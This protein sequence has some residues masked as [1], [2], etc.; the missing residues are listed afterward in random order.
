M[1]RIIGEITEAEQAAYLTRRDVDAEAI[2]SALRQRQH[3]LESRLISE[4]SARFSKGVICVHNGPGPNP[5]EIFTSSDPVQWMESLAGWLLVRSYTS[6]PVDTHGIPHP[7]CEDDAGR[8]YASIF[9]QAGADPELLGRLGP[10]LGLSSRDFGGSYDPSGCR[11]FPLIREKIGGEPAQFAQVHRSLAYDVGLTSQLASLFLLLFIHHERPEHQVQLKDDAELSMADGGPLLGARLTPDL[12]PLLAW[13]GQLAPKAVSI[14]PESAPRPID[15]RHHLSVICP[16]IASTG[17]GVADEGLTQSVE[18]ITQDISSASRI[19]DSL[20]TRWDSSPDATSNTGKLRAALERLGR[21]SGDCYADTYYSV[22]AA[23]PALLDL[24]HDLETL[25]QLVLLD[26]NSSEI[27][28]AQRYIAD[29]RVP[30]VGFPNLAVDRDA[31]LTGLSPSRLTR[32]RS[33]GWN[34][35]ARDAA[36][37]KIR[38]TR[39]YREHHRQFHDALSGFQSGLQSAKKKW[40]ALELLNTISELGP[41]AGAGLERNLASLPPGPLPCSFQGTDVVLSH[42][43]YCLECRISLEQTVPSAA[44]ARLAPQVD[45]ALGEKTQKLSRLLVEKALAGRTEARWREF[46]QIVQASELS[47]LANTLDSD[48][49]S[50]I[51]QVLD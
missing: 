43:P 16:E 40:A 27:I 10:A 21:I 36:A 34:A 45:I 9:S 8:L 13:D 31:L 28:E 26:E 30:T 50:F 23:Y 4:E 20:E 15:A 35:I 25:R 7:I 47:S 1:N 17:A 6:L 19:L 49:V 44:L 41:P 46:L 33:R 12:V 38:Y 5:E 42:E 3:N 37:F 14:G 51:R 39:A 24:K 18:S 2:N 22:R 32:S 11:V 48:L 29:A